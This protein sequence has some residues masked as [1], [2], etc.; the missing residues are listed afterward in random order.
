MATGL[1]LATAYGSIA[2]AHTQ[3]GTLV[4]LGAIDIF[5]VTCPIDAS[6][7]PARLFIQVRDLT[8]SNPTVSIKATKSTISATSTDPVG[9]DAAYSPGV[10]VNGGSG[11]YLMNV[12]K[13]TTGSVTQSYTA[14]FHCQ[15]AGG[16][17]TTTNVRQTQ[18]Q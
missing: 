5:Q 10:V 3:S 7:T 8:A 14:Q 17:H 4:A 12:Y 11:T 2:S 18:N 15:T 13:T 9:G 1:L 16:V 6:G